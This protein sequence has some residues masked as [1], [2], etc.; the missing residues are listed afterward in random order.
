MLNYRF[1]DIEAAISVLIS[2]ARRIFPSAFQEEPQN[3]L[4]NYNKF[5][6]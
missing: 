3:P 5:I 4:Q 1:I 2:L 6:A